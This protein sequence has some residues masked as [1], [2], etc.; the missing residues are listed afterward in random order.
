[1]VGSRQFI[2]L[3][4][5][6]SINAASIQG[7]DGTWAA[8]RILSPA[9]IF[10]HQTTSTPDKRPGALLNCSGKWMSKMIK[11]H[12]GYSGTTIMTATHQMARDLGWSFCKLTPRRRC[13]RSVLGRSPRRS[14]SAGAL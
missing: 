4:R 5:R 6:Q 2:A 9:S 11:A 10:S 8:A 14:P 1:M 7:S 13:Y 3:G 12:P